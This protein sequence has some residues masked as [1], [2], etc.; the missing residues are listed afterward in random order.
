MNIW[1]F[2]AF[3]HPMLTFVLTFYVWAN[4]FFCVA[5]YVGCAALFGVNPFDSNA[6]LR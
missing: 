6:R 4:V 1:L 3:E 5:F 2:F